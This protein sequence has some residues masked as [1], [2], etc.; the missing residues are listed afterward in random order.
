MA[1]VFTKPEVTAL[2]V[3]YRE[4]Q[5]NAKKGGRV[6]TIRFDYFCDLITRNCHYCGSPP[7]SLR[8]RCGASVLYSGIDRVGNERGYTKEN[9]IPC[10]KKCNFLKGRF[11]PDGFLRQ[12]NAVAIYFLKLK[13]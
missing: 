7:L 6:F 1:K 2:K 5:C 8:T 13:T 10:C 12:V 3:L 9:C 11:T 4:Y